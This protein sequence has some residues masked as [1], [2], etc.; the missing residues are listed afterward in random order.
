MDLDRSENLKDPGYSCLRCHMWKGPR[1]GYD[2]VR[3]DRYASG[4]CEADGRF[5]KND[6]CCQD[7]IRLDKHSEYQ[8]FKRKLQDFERSTKNT[9]KSRRSSKTKSG[10]KG[11]GLLFVIIILCLIGMCGKRTT[12]KNEQQTEK[13]TVSTESE[14]IFEDS[15]KRFLTD[16]EVKNLSKDEI[17][18]AI[19]EIYARRGRAY[20][21]PELKEYFSSKSWYNP[22]YSKSEFS[23]EVFNEY[24]KANI[25]LLVKYR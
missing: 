15:D 21:T 22:Q 18:I 10:S 5:H 14:F 2:P 24:E 23:E 1:R 25:K 9:K 17:R 20:E 11:G 3:C 12:Q 4:R 13:I 6:D 8:K 16:D 7:Y 19:N